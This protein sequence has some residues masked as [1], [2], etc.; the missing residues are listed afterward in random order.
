[1][2]FRSQVSRVS[3]KCITTGPKCITAA[4]DACKNLPDGDY[5]ACEGCTFY[6]SCSGG[7]NWAN[8]PCPDTKQQGL[9]GRLVWVAR[10]AN[11]GV[12]DYFSSTCKECAT[13]PSCTS[14]SATGTQCLTRAVSSCV[15]LPDGDYQACE[16]CTYYHSC[17]NGLI[18][19]DRQCAKKTDGTKL[20]WVT[21]KQARGHCDWTGSTCKNCP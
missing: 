12:C 8:R 16:G 3:G 2:L 9:R 5:Q 1:M 19:A 18:A 20:V 13:G 17:S 4:S 14:G 10:S 15:G 21:E 11:K 6:H 7:V